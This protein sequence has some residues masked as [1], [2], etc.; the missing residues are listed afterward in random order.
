MANRKGRGFT[1]VEM[2]V[3][4]TVIGTLMAILLPAIR[5]IQARSQATTC[6]NNQK[7]LASAVVQYETSK[8]RYP[9]YVEVLVDHPAGWPAVLLETVRGDL[10][11]VWRSRWGSAPPRDGTGKE[12]YGAGLDIFHCP[13]DPSS[14]SWVLSYVANCGQ[15]DAPQRGGGSVPP[16]WPYNGVFHSHD[17]RSGKLSGDQLVYVSS[18]GIKDGTQYTLML[19]E[20]VQAGQW[21][22]PYRSSTEGG[23]SNF[24]LGDLFSPPLEASIGMVW[25][26]YESPAKSWMING[27]F[28]EAGSDPLITPPTGE[29][30]DSSAG[31]GANWQYYK[32]ARPSG[33][34]GGFVVAVFCDTHAMRLKENI[35][36]SVFAQLM[37][38]SSREV[39]RA[40]SVDKLSLPTEWYQPISDSDL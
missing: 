16:D 14:E 22:D 40:G 12:L 38:T 30:D 35:A 6:T 17:S 23:Q 25:F 5:A 2:L 10:W 1:L 11:P 26:P 21:T 29:D 36:Y 20:N 4:I 9:G 34:H 7:Q 37:S 28:K 39:R 13:S 19:S 3:V 18:P 24:N 27:K 31:G 8:N 33:N 32:Y 15:P